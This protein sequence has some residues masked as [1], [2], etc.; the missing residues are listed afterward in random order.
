MFTTKWVVE[1]F[2]AARDLYTHSHTQVGADV[3]SIK[4]DF[5]RF[6]DESTA[7]S[8]PLKL[9]K[10]GML[11]LRSTLDWGM[12]EGDRLGWLSN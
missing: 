4:G 12:F 3:H 10:A 9:E 2:P 6:P 7:E 5:E 11:S 8:A 1:S